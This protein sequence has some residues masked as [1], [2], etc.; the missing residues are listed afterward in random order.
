MSQPVQ[1]A[2]KELRP[3]GSA[4]RC[5]TIRGQ[6]HIVPIHTIRP[7]TT[8]PGTKQSARAAKAA[9]RLRLSQPASLNQYWDSGSGPK[10]TFRL[11]SC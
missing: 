9:I 10:P 2:F 1:R 5:R 3:D 11:G 6:P 7:P 8:V 4:S